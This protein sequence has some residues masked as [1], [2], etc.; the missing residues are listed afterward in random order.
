LEAENIRYAIRLPA[1]QVLQE[2]SATSSSGRSA[3]HPRSR[4]SP[5]PASTIR[6]RAGPEPV[7]WSPR[8]SG[9]RVSPMPAAASS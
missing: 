5:T 6:P 9:T 2:R 1:N 4:S 7:G 3:G 8:S